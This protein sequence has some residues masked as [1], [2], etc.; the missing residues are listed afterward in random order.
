MKQPK[1]SQKYHGCLDNLDTSL[2]MSEAGFHLPVTE[3]WAK[4][5]KIWYANLEKAAQQFF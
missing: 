5:I 1:S 3:N 4:A 2:L